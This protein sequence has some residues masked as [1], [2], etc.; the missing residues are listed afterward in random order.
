M[1][2]SGGCPL[3][4]ACGIDFSDGDDFNTEPI[5]MQGYFRYHYILKFALIGESTWNLG[6][7]GIIL[8]PVGE[9]PDI[10]LLRSSLAKIKNSIRNVPFAITLRAIERI[11]LIY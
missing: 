11:S 7:Y 6:R 2:K 9:G 3:F 5:G 4:D 1:Q 8:S 10:R